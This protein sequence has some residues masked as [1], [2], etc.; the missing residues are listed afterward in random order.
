MSGEGTVE[1]SIELTGHTHRLLVIS[2]GNRR[3]QARMRRHLRPRVRLLRYYPQGPPRSDLR[4]V[5]T[6]YRRRLRTRIARRR[7][8]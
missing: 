8:R 4:R 7:N 3:R 6:E 2:P 1:Y 5:K